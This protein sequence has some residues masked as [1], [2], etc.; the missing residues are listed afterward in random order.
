MQAQ[1]SIPTFGDDRLPARFWAKVCVMPSG[2]WEWTARRDHNGYGRF[3]IGSLTDG[4]RQMVFAHRLA[5]ETL[6]GP[7]A[8]GLESDHL[9]RNRACVWPTHIEPVTRSVNVQRSPLVGRNGQRRRGEANGQAK[10]TAEDIPIIRALRGK[11]YQVELAA[12]FGVSDGQ[13]SRIQ[14]GTSWTYL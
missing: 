11:V 12:R 7:I 8:E 13:I 4:S 10:L 2:C 3:R 14:R 9:C 5:Y 6:I 1:L